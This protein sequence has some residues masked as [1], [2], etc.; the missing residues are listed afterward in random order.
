MNANHTQNKSEPS[1]IWLMEIKTASL[2][3]GVSLESARKGGVYLL[4]RIYTGLS[5]Q[6]SKHNGSAV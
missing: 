2:P 5:H 6:Q 4:D 3:T 1:V